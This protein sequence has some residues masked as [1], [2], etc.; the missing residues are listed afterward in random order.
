M[1]LRST[2]KLNNGVQMPWVGLGV[3][4]SP[5]GKETE[6]AVRWAL[7]IGYR[8]IDTAAA[9]KNEKDVRPSRAAACPATRCSS[10]PSC[11]TPTRA[12]TPP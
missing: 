9:Y 7:E 5:E 12:S 2:V 4:L 1:D 8:H 10:P 3:F 11:G 6:S